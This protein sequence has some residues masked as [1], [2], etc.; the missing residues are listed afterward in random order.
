MALDTGCLKL[1]VQQLAQF[2]ACSKPVND[3]MHLNA[4]CSGLFQCIDHPASDFIRIKNI[5]FQINL[6]MRVFD[7]VQQGREK[8]LAIL[9]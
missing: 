4:S 6:G 9:Q 1:P 5:R 3:H 2:A 8:I 7:C